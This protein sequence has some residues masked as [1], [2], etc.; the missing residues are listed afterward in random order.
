[1]LEKRGLSMLELRL[2]RRMLA[3]CGDCVPLLGATQRVSGGVGM[4]LGECEALLSTTTGSVLTC[5]VGMGKG[6]AS[7]ISASPSSMG[8]L[9]APLVTKV[10]LPCSAASRLALEDRILDTAAVAFA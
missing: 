6:A 7:A 1:M 2:G 10:D 5:E 4:S 8:R 3:A 9:V